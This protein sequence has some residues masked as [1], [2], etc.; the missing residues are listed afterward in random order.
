MLMARRSDTRAG[1]APRPVTGVDE[2]AV[3]PERTVRENFP[4]A[5]RILPARHRAA[6]GAIYRYARLVDDI[7]DEAPPA[8]RTRLLDLVDRD[9]D[10]IYAG[11]APEL[12]ALRAVGTVA[13]E[14]DIPQDPL[15]KLVRANRQDQEAARY[16]TWDQL[17]AYCAL[18]ADPVGH[19]VLH[20][21][22][23]A[24]PER[25]ELSDRVCTALQVIEHCQD[26][27]E[28]FAAG[29]VYLPAEDLRAFG[30]TDADLGAARTTPTR[31]RGAVARVADRA[32][33]LLDS[34]APLV[35]RLEGW[36]RISV[37][38][39]LA[40]GRATLA[41]LRDGAYDVHAAALRPS[42]ARTLA[43]ALTILGGK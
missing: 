5:L 3:P 38:G 16:D 32:C 4:V 36:A 24:T 28:D 13:L 40:G 37:A 19:L 26:V 15:R 22:D 35:G 23:A 42:R 33:A 29:R 18:S 9:I 6:L 8:D 2:P 31:L 34:G 41:A 10:R 21:F 30:C 43:E 27:A 25:V 7:G 1:G 14:H 11:R 39:Y 20:V 12:P 17:V